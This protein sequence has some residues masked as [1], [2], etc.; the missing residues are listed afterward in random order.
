MREEKESFFVC[1]VKNFF[2]IFKNKKATIPEH[3]NCAFS[4]KFRDNFSKSI[5][6]GSLSF[7]FSFVVFFCGKHYEFYG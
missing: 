5:T 3:Q 2:A 4:H 1:F 6:E 7:L